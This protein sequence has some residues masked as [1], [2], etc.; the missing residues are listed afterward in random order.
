[1]KPPGKLILF[2]VCVVIFSL[3]LILYVAS[4]V[5]PKFVIKVNENDFDVLGIEYT[6]VY[7]Y[8]EN[9]SLGAVNLTVKTNVDNL[10]IAA[11]SETNK[12]YKGCSYQF[13]KSGIHKL[14]ACMGDPAYQ[15][16]VSPIDVEHEF[17]VCGNY[18]WTIF[19]KTEPFCK[20]ITLPPYQK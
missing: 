16:G 14:A 4:P 9:E 3:F 18:P 7:P 19:Y 8:R 20:Y 13:E 15:F 12:Y 5:I 2:G 11:Y 1:M 10:I 17:R 6:N